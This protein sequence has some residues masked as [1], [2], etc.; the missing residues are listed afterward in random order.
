MRPL[1][2]ERP[3]SENVLFVFYDYETIQDTQLTSATV[4]IPNLVCIQQFCSLCEKEPDSDVDC[5]R[6]GTRSHAFCDDPVG[7][8][9]AFLCKQRE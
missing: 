3:K 8:L 6:C 1:K 9:L 7:D 2:K 5:V 4:H